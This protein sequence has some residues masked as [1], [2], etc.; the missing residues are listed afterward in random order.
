MLQKGDF[1][2]SRIGDMATAGKKGRTAAFPNWP[3]KQ[4]L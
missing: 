2:A 3:M 1:R 4:D